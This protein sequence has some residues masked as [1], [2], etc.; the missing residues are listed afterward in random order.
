MHYHGFN[1][2]SWS[3]SRCQSL[4]LYKVHIYFQIYNQA[5]L[6]ALA[7]WDSRLLVSSTDRVW[8]GFQQ[9]S[10][11]FGAG[12]GWYLQVDGG[13]EIGP[14]PDQAVGKLCVFHYVT[15]F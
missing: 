14:F 13:K 5:Q 10:G 9:S 6:D 2:N 3:C 4:H 12:I 8:I 7:A 15:G 1:R 11:A